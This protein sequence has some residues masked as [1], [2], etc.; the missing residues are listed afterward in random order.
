MKSFKKTVKNILNFFGYVYYRT[1]SL[2]PIWLF[3][4]REG[5]SLYQ[6]QH[7]IFSA[8]EKDIIRGLHEKGI[9]ITHISQ[10][11]PDNVFHELRQYVEKR[12]K[13][14][15][16][17]AWK[18]KRD[19]MIVG[20][21]MKSKEYFL[22]NVWEGPHVLDFTHPFIRLSVSE[23]LVRVVSGYLGVLPKFRYWALEATMP[24]PEGMR[25]YASQEWHRDPDDQQLVKVFLYLNDI[26]E[27]AGPFSYLQYSQRGGKWRHLFPQ[28]PPRGTYKVPRAVN[29]FI[30]KEDI[31]TCTGK[32]GTII[33]CDTSGLH[34]GGYAS[35]HQRFMYTSAYLTNASPWAIRYSYPR[36]F[37][38]KALPSYAQYVV[39]NNP[40]QKEP[41]FY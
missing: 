27:T 22:V 1:R 21:K 37:N 12:W 6:N 2:R 40:H 39:K 34:R 33:F 24:M 11:F 41:R 25:T 8:H 31:I 18:N 30:P 15:D 16:I 14:A 13:D 38:M 36:D 32:A 5:R 7:F 9:Y 4:N 19:T 17:E 29:D 3:L 28:H 35:S 10:F 20:D 26:D 23:P